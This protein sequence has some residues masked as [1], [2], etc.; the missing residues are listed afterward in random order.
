MPSILFGKLLVLLWSDRRSIQTSSTEQLKKNNL[1]ENKKMNWFILN[2]NCYNLKMPYLS[3]I[4]LK[5]LP[6]TTICCKCLGFQLAHNRLLYRLFPQ[7]NIWNNVFTFVF[8]FPSWTKTSND[9][10]IITLNNKVGY[11]ISFSCTSTCKSYLSC[12]SS[13]WV[14]GKREVFRIVG[15]CICFSQ[16]EINTTLLPWKSENEVVL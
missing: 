16:E 1:I 6:M 5:L 10:K 8:L 2:C 11:R 9:S 13:F 14:Q 12:H 4:F 15:A 3:I 7:C